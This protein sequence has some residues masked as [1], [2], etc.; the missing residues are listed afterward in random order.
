MS[1]ADLAR[2]LGL[3]PRKMR[4]GPPAGRY[5]TAFEGPGPGQGEAVRAA[6]G[7]VDPDRHARRQASHTNRVTPGT[8][9]FGAG[10][11]PHS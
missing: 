1:A 9:T 6:G 4:A 5:Q 11:G 2:G 7:R 8:A 3:L 10:N